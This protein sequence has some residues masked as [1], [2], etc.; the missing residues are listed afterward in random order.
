MGGKA[1]EAQERGTP[2]S[3]TVHLSLEQKLQ[4]ELDRASAV[5]VNGS[6]E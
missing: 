5:D 4:T 2:E 1:G 6:Q 3:A